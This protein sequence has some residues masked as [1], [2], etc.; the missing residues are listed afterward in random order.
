MTFV[1]SQWQ[2][3]KESKR[4]QKKSEEESDDDEESEDEGSDDSSSSSDIQDGLEQPKV[5]VDIQT[6]E[7][8]KAWRIKEEMS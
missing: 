8:D 5:E 2:K 3:N 6:P 7:M 1:G 4:K